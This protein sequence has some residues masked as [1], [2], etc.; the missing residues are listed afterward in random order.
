MRLVL[1]A[2]GSADPRS[3]S[4]AHSLLAC[5]RRL[6]P[7]LD[8]RVAFCEQNSP[9]LRDALASTRSGRAVVVPLLLA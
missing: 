3:A 4:T 5:I 1:T 7:G 6:R 9:N 2:H 8:A